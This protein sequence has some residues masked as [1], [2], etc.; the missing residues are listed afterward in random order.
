VLA[1]AVGRLVTL[2]LV[3]QEVLVV[4]AMQLTLQVLTMVR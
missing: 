2:E 3:A 1:V 4:V